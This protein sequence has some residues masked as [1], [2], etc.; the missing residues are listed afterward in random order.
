MCGFDVVLNIK[1]IKDLIGLVHRHYH[2]SSRQTTITTKTT[3]FI[4]FITV[5]VQSY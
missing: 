2:P 4:K 3:A 1:L 5:P